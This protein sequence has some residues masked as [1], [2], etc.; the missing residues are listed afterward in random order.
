MFLLLLAS[1]AISEIVVNEDAID[2][3]GK[4]WLNYGRDYS[5]QRFSPLDKI[6]DDNI[7]EL[8]LSWSYRFPTARGLEAT[9]L[10]HEGVIYV[11]T[12]WSN[13][14]ALDAKNG[15]ALWT[16]DAQVSK[17]HLA[18]T[19]CGPVNRGVAL[20]QGTKDEFHQLGP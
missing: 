8:N 9:P 15:N 3:P 2:N 12:A 20:W 4:N 17:A 6:N 7:Q 5:E 18:K 13:V 16:F 10:V 1:D 19:C 11:T 14:Y